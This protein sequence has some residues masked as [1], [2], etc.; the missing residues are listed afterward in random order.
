MND[1]EYLKAVTEETIKELAEVGWDK[2]FSD[3]ELLDKARLIL[4]QL[5]FEHTAFRNELF[6][7]GCIRSCTYAAERHGFVSPAQAGDDAREYI[8]EI[9]NKAKTK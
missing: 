2:R 7:I 1:Y 8:S 4:K 6:N 5:Q 9:L 3:W